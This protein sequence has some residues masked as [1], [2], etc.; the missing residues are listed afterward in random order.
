MPLTT[1]QIAQQLIQIPI[2][3]A[4]NLLLELNVIIFFPLESGAIMN[5]CTVRRANGK[6][7]D[8]LILSIN[9]SSSPDFV[10]NIYI[11]VVQTSG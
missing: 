10:V 2:K 8:L 4:F 9:Q 5:E 6:N 11:F 3:F 7:G 1:L